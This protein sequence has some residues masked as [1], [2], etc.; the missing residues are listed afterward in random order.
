MTPQHPPGGASG[1]AVSSVAG[2]TGAVTLVKADVSLTSVD[3]TADTA[4]PVSTA[5]STAIAL[6][7]NTSHTH[8][9]ADVSSGTVAVVRLGTGVASATTYLRGDQTWATPAGT[10]GANLTTTLAAAT[11]T[12]VSDTGTDAIV[13][14]ADAT[15]AGVMTAAQQTKLAGVATG[16]TANATDALLRDRTTHTGTQAPATITGLLADAAELNILDGALLSTAELNFVDGVTSAIQAQFTGKAATAHAHAAADVTSGTMAT[17]RLAATGVAS[18]TTYLRGDQTWATPAGGGSS[19]PDRLYAVADY[20]ADNT[21]V[22]NTHVALQNAINAAATAKKLLIVEP[23]T[24]R[25]GDVLVAPTNLRMSAYGA[26]FQCYDPE[27]GAV[28]NNEPV[29]NIDLKDNV[30][31]EGLEID[32]RETAFVGVTQYKHGINIDRSTNVTIRNVYAHDCKGDGIILN[33]QSHPGGVHN[34]NIVIDNCRCNSNNR[35][36]M[37]I[38]DGVG[39]HVYG[40]EFN[41]NTGQTPAFGIDIEPDS[42]NCRLNDINFWGVECI[43]NGE[44]GFYCAMRDVPVAANPQRGILFSGGRISGNGLDVTDFYPGVALWNTHGVTFENVEISG[45]LRNQGVDAIRN[46]YDLMFRGCKF[47]GNGDTGITIRPSTG[48]AARRINI[49]DCDFFGNS[50]LGTGAAAAINLQFDTSEVTIINTTVRAGTTNHSHG[51]ITSSTVGAVKIRDGAMTGAT[52][53]A[54][55]HVNTVKV[56]R[57]VTGLANAG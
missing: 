8:D 21:G 44:A 15:N 47:R 48:H 23:G 3:D 19:S 46:C 45:N 12:I 53:A 28:T 16:A 27:L 5:Q 43:G 54:S 14:A 4:K 36:G 32:G 51:L 55:I 2:K 37:A 18:A 40:G 24:Y 22:A 30:T 7:A 17:A 34:V 42:T 38:T 56:I 49:I 6:K 35:G 1:G 26:L 33:D 11:V 13:P 41:A 20:A 52:A 9:G 31:V 25:I 57:E 50:G 39:V 29:I 10:G